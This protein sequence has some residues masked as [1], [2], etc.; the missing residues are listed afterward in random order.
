MYGVAIGG[1]GLVAL[2]AAEERD[3]VGGRS[4]RVD[5]LKPHIHRTNRYTELLESGENVEEM[6]GCQCKLSWL[7]GL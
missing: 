1:L 6:V 4:I 3:I 2:G 5:V 7:D